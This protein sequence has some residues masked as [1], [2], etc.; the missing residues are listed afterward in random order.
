MF[1][2]HVSGRVFR[3]TTVAVIAQRGWRSAVAR[4]AFLFRV[5]AWTDCRSAIVRR[6]A[7][8]ITYSDSAAN[9]GRRD[10]VFEVGPR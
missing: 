5:T 6:G 1:T 8:A 10:N 9:A 2:G 7:A 4:S 3:D